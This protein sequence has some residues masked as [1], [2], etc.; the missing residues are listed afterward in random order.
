MRALAMLKAPFHVRA[1]S[2]VLPPGS[3]AIRPESADF[4]DAVTRGSS[5][6]AVVDPTLA[7]RDRRIASSLSRTHLGT[8]LYIRLTPEY[9]QASVGLIRELGTDEIVTYGL[10]DDPRTFA[11]ILRRQSRAERGHF[12]MRLLAPQIAALPC[13]IRRGLTHMAEQGDRIDSVDRMASVCGVTRGTLSHHFKAA[14]IMSAWGLVAGLQFLRNYDVLIDDSLT[15]LDVARAVGL[16]SARSLQRQ[17]VAI[18]GLTLQDIRTPVS[19]EHLA[20][21]IAGVLTAR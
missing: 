18:S 12:L 13:T 2:A 9:A 3:I 10:N 17:C 8:V 14:G 11:G 7:E 20:S 6:V 1:Q 4:I 19:I 16:S 5:D 21:C 15:V